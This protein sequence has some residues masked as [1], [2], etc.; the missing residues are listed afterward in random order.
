MSKKKKSQEKEYL[1]DIRILKSQYVVNGNRSMSLDEAKE[2]VRNYTDRIMELGKNKEAVIQLQKEVGLDSKKVVKED[3]GLFKNLKLPKGQLK[4]QIIK[5]QEGK[6][7]LQFY[8]EAKK[9]W[10]FFDEVYAKSK[11][12]A[13]KKGYDQIGTEA[14]LKAIFKGKEDENGKGNEKNGSDD[15]GGKDSVEEKT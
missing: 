13:L 10:C 5:K 14:K 12:N 8:D 11:I 6:Y 15:G 9:T 2:F 1:D 3:S 4:N 7:I